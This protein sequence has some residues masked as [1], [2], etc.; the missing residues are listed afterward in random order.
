MAEPT[1]PAGSIEELLDQAVRAVNEGDLAT[2]HHL[3]GQVLSED[4]GNRDAGY[5]LTTGAAPEGELRRLTI[6]A[7]D[8]VGSTELSERLDPELYRTLVGRYRGLC[9]TT[10]ESVY[11]GHIVSIKGD[12]M[13]ALFGFPTPHEN[14]ADRAVK[15]ALDL[16]DAVRELSQETQRSLGE[17]VDVR[18]GVHRGLVFI[19]VDEADVYGLA[20]NVV[21]R[22]EGLATPG[23]VVISESMRHLVADRFD[24]EPGAPQ[25][26]KGVSA[27]I[28]PFTV[29]G[30]RPPGSSDRHAAPIVGRERELAALHAAWSS[31]R[32]G[33]APRTTAVLIRGEPGIGKSRLVTALAEGARAQGAVVVE[34]TGSP[35]HTSAGFHPV[36][37]L[38][39]A[40]CGIGQTADAR[41]RLGRL[42]DE[43]DA[44]GAGD[45]AAVPLLAPILG[46]PPSAGYEPAAADARKLNEE[47]TH[48]VEDYIT[49]LFGG[50]PGL[51][52]AEDVQ[53]FDDSTVALLEQLTTH[54]PGHLL[55]LITSRG[56]TPVPVG[57]VIELQPLPM[58]ECLELLAAL[59][60]DDIGE[61]KARALAERSDGVPLYLEELLRGWEHTAPAAVATEPSGTVPDALYEPLVARLYATPAGMPV[62]A[63]AATIG[64]EAERSILA[65]VL[66]LPASDLDAELEALVAG[67]ILTRSGRDRDRYRFRHELLRS[68]AYELQPPSRRRQL[69]GRIGDLLV[70][71]GETDGVLDW[72]LVATHYEEAARASDAA[73]AHA[74]SADRA[75]QRGALAEARGHLGRAIDLVAMLPEDADRV[76]R[77]VDLRLRRGFLAMTAEGAGSA[78]AAADYERCL[79]LAMRDVHG[80]EMFSS[81]I[82]VWAYH[83]SRAELARARQVLEALRSNLAGSRE[84]FR[85][86]NRAGFG[87]ISWFEGDFGTARAILE[88]AVDLLGGAGVDAD[89]STVWFVPNDPTASMHTH[90]ALA[91][92]MSGDTAGADEQLERMA[93]V[94][95]DLEFPQGPWSTAYGTWL[96]S[97]LKIERGDLDD[98]DAGATDLVGLGHLH[99]F[100]SWAVIGMTQQAAVAATRALGESRPEPATVRTHATT[101][102]TMVAMWQ[103]VDL[104]IFLPYYLTL[105]GAALAAAGDDAG[106]R[107]RYGEA[108]ALGERTGM[109]FYAAET[110]RHLAHLAPDPAEIDRVLRDALDLARAQGARPFELRVALDLHDLNGEAALPLLERAV[111]GFAPDASSA[112]LETARAR[113]ARAG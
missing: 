48:A 92:F 72:N 108:L 30:E 111:A 78:D 18:I 3:A 106:A 63:A 68:V 97:W 105:A 66:D 25:S 4:A 42:R 60:P 91:R 38:L 109:R 20:A 98:A 75:R 79:Q 45:G 81:L 67:R 14:D 51:L 59:G 104:L 2:A 29:L 11:D 19:D 9:R 83:L 85:P 39:E 84:Y 28:Q 107:D 7:C 99:G 86:A 53:W 24:L 90:L 31:A 110:T 55:V 34:L 52:V 87:M 62:A 82:S 27:P 65:D 16:C 17:S 95:A 1:P 32:T 40:R 102:D 41:A 5:L 43:L 70:H 35:F 6:L 8:L 100:D 13:L 26:V 112:E 58:E 33:R 96:A 93:A 64:R 103:M 69:H 47:I 54:G 10:I 56:D 88:E 36:Q 76:R 80:D 89:V 101:L 61:T 12:G 57:T 94:A 73:H 50:R 15:A 44:A 113:L 49:S 22:L 46:L 77:E 71:A 74:Q 37:T 23:T 21:S